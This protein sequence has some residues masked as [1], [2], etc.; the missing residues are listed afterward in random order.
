[1]AERAKKEKKEELSKFDRFQLAIKKEYSKKSI[2]EITENPVDKLL[3]SIL[4]DNNK[5][6]SSNLIDYINKIQLRNVENIE[7]IWSLLSKEKK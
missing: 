5:K 2:D 3:S 4:F 7:K 1:M 6:K